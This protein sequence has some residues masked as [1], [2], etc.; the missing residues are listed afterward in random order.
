L[1][2]RDPAVV[3]A[4]LDAGT[5]PNERASAEGDPPL[6]FFLRVGACSPTERPTPG[7]VKEVLKSLLAKGADARIADAH[8]NTALMAAAMGG[9]DRETMV[10]LL[11]AGAVVD[12]K[13]AAGL[14]AFEMGLFSGHDGLEELIAAGYRLPPDKAALYRQGYAKNPKSLVLIDKAAGPAKK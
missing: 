3:Q 6:A 13:N 14:T 8:G 4:Y 1:T 11:R 9:C 2:E 10:L 12:A 7:P 5:N